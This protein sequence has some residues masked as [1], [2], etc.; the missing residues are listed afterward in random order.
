[1]AGLP[2]ELTPLILRSLTTFT[3][4]PHPK[5]HRAPHNTLWIL[6]FFL[7][8]FGS[9]PVLVSMDWYMSLWRLKIRVNEEERY[10][11]LDHVEDFF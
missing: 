9:E 1:M 6:Y 2:L 4:I 10:F 3:S 11:L 7:F 8:G 5:I